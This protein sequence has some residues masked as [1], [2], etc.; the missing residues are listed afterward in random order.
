M[1]ATYTMMFLKK[2]Q[3]KPLLCLTFFRG[4][5]MVPLAVLVT[6]LFLS[7]L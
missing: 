6:F 1:I 3:F 2:T 7:L 5:S 4:L